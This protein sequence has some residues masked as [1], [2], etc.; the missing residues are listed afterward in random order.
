VNKPHLTRSRRLIWPWDSAAVISARFR[1]A[2]SASRIRLLSECSD[3][4]ILSSLSFRDMLLIS[5]F[6]NRVFLPAAVQRRKS[7]RR[8]KSFGRVTVRNIRF[9]DCETLSDLEVE[10]PRDE[11]EAREGEFHGLTVRTVCPPGGRQGVRWRNEVLP[12]ARR[13]HI[14]FSKSQYFLIFFYKEFQNGTTITT[15]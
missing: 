3:N 15:F 4:Q 8:L 2:F 9:P 5:Y 12:R 11:T 14:R 7:G 10:S 13:Y 1:R 6:G